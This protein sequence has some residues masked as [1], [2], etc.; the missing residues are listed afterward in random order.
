MSEARSTEEKVIVLTNG[1]FCSKEIKPLTQASVVLLFDPTL[2]GGHSITE[3]MDRTK[4]LLLDLACRE[5]DKDG[6]TGRAWYGANKAIIQERKSW[7]VIYQLKKGRPSSV[8]SIEDI[9]RK[10]GVHYVIKYLPVFKGA[11]KTIEFFRSLSSDH[12]PTDSV[13]SPVAVA[14]GKLC[15]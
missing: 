1:G 14:L 3:L 12:L 6:I 7:K 8:K 5:K 15:G 13:C 10:L 9:K 4:V 2:H 11:A